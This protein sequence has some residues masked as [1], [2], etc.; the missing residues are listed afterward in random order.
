MKKVALKRL[1]YGHTAD[2]KTTAIY[3]NAVEEEADLASKMLE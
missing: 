2:M 1:F 3:A